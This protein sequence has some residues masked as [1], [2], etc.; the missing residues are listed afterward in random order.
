MSQDCLAGP[1]FLDYLRAQKDPITKGFFMHV[2]ID[3]FGAINSSKG[4]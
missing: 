2:G 1:E 4:S 3:D